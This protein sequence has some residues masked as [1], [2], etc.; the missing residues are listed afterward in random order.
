MA[1]VTEVVHSGDM[2]TVAVQE[3]EAVQIEELSEGEFIDG[4]EESVKKKMKMFYRKQCLGEHL[5]IMYDIKS[6]KDN[7]FR[8]EYNFSKYIK[9]A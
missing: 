3:T 2:D 4:N 5:Q 9:D 8:N 1:G 7:K 6:T